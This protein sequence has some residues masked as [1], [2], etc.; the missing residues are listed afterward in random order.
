MEIEVVKFDNLGRGIGYLNNKIVFIPKSIPGDILNVE[1]TLE[2]K[3]FCE[4]KITNIIKPSKL[5]QTAICPYFS[6]CGG[7]DL[8]NISLTESLEYK[9]Q[10]VNDILKNNQIDYEI[11]EIIKS[12]ERY[13]YRN[14]VSL[15]IINGQIGFYESGSHQLVEI[16]KCFLCQNSL[17]KIIPDLKDLGINNG[18]ITIRSNYKEEI[19]IIIETSNK[20]EDY[21]NLITNHKIVGL[22]LNNELIYGDDFLIANI[23]NYL[24]KIS[25]DSFFQVNPFICAKLFDLVQEYTKDSSKVLDLYCG[26]GTLSIVAAQNAKE[27]LGVEIVANAILAANVNKLLNNTPNVNFVCA[28][29]KKVLD[30]INA[31]YDTIILDPPRSGVNEQVLTQIIKNK[32]SHLIYISCDPQTLGRDLKIL[33]KNYII[34]E[35]KLLDMF[36]NTHHVESFCVLKLL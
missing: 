14:K 5:R 26:V 16:N 4:A 34:E 32:I 35:I 20:I 3:N 15:K 33:S 30:K 22:I 2:K 21:T 1:L 31:S 7:C 36:P 10:K 29:T 25:Y 27:V 17:N 23:N 12:P 11:K 18:N 19:L 13:N 9:L 24:F 6:K 8:L 28:D